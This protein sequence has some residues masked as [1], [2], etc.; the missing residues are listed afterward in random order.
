MMMYSGMQSKPF[1]RGTRRGSGPR[2]PV[3]SM[4]EPARRTEKEVGSPSGLHVQR[5][6]QETLWT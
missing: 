2:V 6:S 5:N 1:V 3:S 4:G